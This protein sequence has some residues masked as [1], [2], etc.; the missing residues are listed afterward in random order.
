MGIINEKFNRAKEK[1]EADRRAEDG[2]EVMNKIT[3]L[4]NELGSNFNSLNGGELAEIQMKLAGYKFYLVDYIASLNQISEAL[5]LQAKEKKAIRWDEVTADIKALEGRVKNKEQIENVITVE[6]MPIMHE[7]ILYENMF[8][9]YR[10][11]LDAINDI[12]TALVQKIAERKR[13]I[14]QSKIYN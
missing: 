6:V 2:F 12:S 1:F 7:Q 14:E 9:K 8:Y 3:A 4:I 10:L 5:K 13:E 11:K